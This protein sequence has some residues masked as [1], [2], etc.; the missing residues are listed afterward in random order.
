MKFNKA[1]ADMIEIELIS[2]DTAA[3]LNTANKHAIYM[4]NVNVIDFFVHIFG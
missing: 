3:F 1:S 2:A 4:Y